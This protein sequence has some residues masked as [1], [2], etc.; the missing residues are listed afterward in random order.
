MTAEDLTKYGLVPA[1][2][3]RIEDRKLIIDITDSNTVDLEGCI[4]AFLIGGKVVR[5]GSSKAPLRGRLKNYE[6]HITHA[7]KGEKS[8]A[9]AQEAEK[10]SELLPAGKSGDIYARQGTMVTTSPV[11]N[12]RAYMDE[13]SILIGKLFSEEPHDHIL[14]RCKYR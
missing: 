6:R 13:E 10:W 12:F 4:Y 5:I 14:N 9:P 3:V 2:R 8:P 11:G 1:A 7:L